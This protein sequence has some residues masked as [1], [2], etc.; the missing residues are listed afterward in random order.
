[1][2]ACVVVAV[3]ACEAAGG[4]CRVIVVFCVLSMA[5]SMALVI[6][7]R[8]SIVPKSLCLVR[9]LGWRRVVVVLVVMLTALVIGRGTLRRKRAQPATCVQNG[10]LMRKNR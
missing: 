1:V 9:M 6:S 3:A 8:F 10:P 2:V 5:V 4:V 7:M